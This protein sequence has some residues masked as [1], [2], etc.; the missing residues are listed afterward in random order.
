MTAV[1]LGTPIKGK[2]MAEIPALT[3]SL[4]N[5]IVELRAEVARLKG[6]RKELLDELKRRYAPP[7]GDGETWLGDFIRKF[8]P[9]YPDVW[10]EWAKE[11]GI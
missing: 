8:D 3:Q 4:A 5:E 11:T 9:D 7:K 1:L 2:T 6:E 10:A